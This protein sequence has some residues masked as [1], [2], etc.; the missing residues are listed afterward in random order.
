MFIDIYIYTP[1]NLLLKNLDTF[2]WSQKGGH[3]SKLLKKASLLILFLLTE[4]EYATVR[5][6][7]AQLQKDHASFKEVG[8]ESTLSYALV[9][10][11]LSEEA[12]YKAV[13]RQSTLSYA[14]VRECPSEE[15]VQ[16]VAGRDSTLSYALIGEDIYLTSGSSHKLEEKKLDAEQGSTVKY[17]K[18]ITGVKLKLNED[19]YRGELVHLTG[20]PS[21]SFNPSIDIASLYTK[22]KK[23]PP[24]NPHTGG[25]IE[26]TGEKGTHKEPTV[27]SASKSQRR[28]STSGFEIPCTSERRPSASGKQKVNA[29][30]SMEGIY[31]MLGS[32][33]ELKGLTT[34]EKIMSLELLVSDMYKGLSDEH[35]EGRREEGAGHDEGEGK[36]GREGEGGGG[37]KRSCSNET[38]STEAEKEDDID[39]RFY[40]N[41]DL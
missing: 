22:V 33:D 12:G 2:A 11:D 29:S 13:E 18:V 6:R 24:S 7:G 41:I 40:V 5:T 17:S 4:T 15:A 8:R 39:D 38:T 27:I 19:D 9:G 21:S 30:K 31:D 1:L 16:K 10:E 23:D 26:N 35:V 28:N 32:D 34:E 20:T 37:E 3:V 14:T 36:G 25:G